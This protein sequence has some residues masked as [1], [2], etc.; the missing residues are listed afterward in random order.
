MAYHEVIERSI[1][2]NELEKETAKEL[3]YVV[4]QQW[5]KLKN[6]SVD[7]F[8]TSFLQREGTLTLTEEG[9]TLV[10][11]SKAYDLLLQTLPWGL[12]FI[13]NSWMEQPIF[14]EWN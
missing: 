5:E 6:T 13:K 14:V 11:E 3:L 8:Q 4:T 2:L 10:V 1:E 9:W 7:G 12:S